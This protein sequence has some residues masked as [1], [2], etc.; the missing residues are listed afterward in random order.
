[1]KK[2]FEIIDDYE[3]VTCRLCGLRAKRIYGKHLDKTHKMTSEDYKRLFPDAPLSSEISNVNMGK[4]MKTDKYKNMFSEKFSG[5]NNPNHKSKTTEEE[6]RERSPFSKKFVKYKNINPDDIEEHVSKFAKNALKDRVSDTTLEYWMNK[7]FSEEDAKLKLKERQTTFTLDKCIEKYGE[8]EGINIFNDRQERWQNSL[9]EN[10]NLKYGYSKAS[11]TLFDEITSLYNIF[12]KE[13]LYFAIKNNEYKLKDELNG[14]LYLYDFT[15][16]KNM[17]MIEYN[18]DQYHANP[19]MYNKDDQPHP[20]R[21]ELKYKASEIW[22]RDQRKIE[23]ANQN[24]FE[25]LTI[26]DSEFKKNPKEVIQ[27]CREF[28]GL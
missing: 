13:Y 10:G 2:D 14:G 27:R 12:D 15:D 4:H 3:K 6:R 21:K 25:V 5:E 28:L 22:K 26:W 9:L 19:K 16:T 17:K 8:E 23:V 11:Q 7:G 1:M 20:F 24:G 18:G